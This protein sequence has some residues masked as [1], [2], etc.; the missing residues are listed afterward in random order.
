[1]KKTVTSQLLYSIRKIPGYVVL[2][3]VVM[4]AGSCST[5]KPKHLLKSNIPV[6][7]DSLIMDRDGN[8]YSVKK[9]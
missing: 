1:M 5:A 4:T 3:I 2:S 9:C 6:L 7:Q 8:K